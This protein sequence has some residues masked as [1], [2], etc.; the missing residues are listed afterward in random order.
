VNFKHGKVRSRAYGVW[1]SM[2]ARCNN[3]KCPA[4]QNYGGRGITVC[5]DWATFAQFYRDM[6]DPPDGHTLERIDNDKGYSPDNCQWV[7][8]TVQG[9]NTTRRANGIRPAIT[10]R[11]RTLALRRTFSTAAPPR[12]KSDSETD[13]R[14][15]MADAIYFEPPL[16]DDYPVYPTYWYVVD[17]GPTRSPIQGVVRDLKRTMHA[18]QICRCDAVK[19]GLIR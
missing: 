12:A 4:Y 11:R 15:T 9:R 18:K 7:T 1:C 19:R 10:R 8:R 6:G 16:E 5:A 14:R 13:W 2:K 17:G 3:P